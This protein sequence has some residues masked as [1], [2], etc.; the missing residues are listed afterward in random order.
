M[1]ENALN[2]FARQLDSSS[3][4]GSVQI[5]QARAS[6]E[7]QAQVWSAKQY[8][9][10]Q[11]AAF[12]RAME[13]CRRPSLASVATYAFP[14]GK[15]TVRGA[16]IRLAE[17]L[18]TAWGNVS[19][20]TME[21]SRKPG[22]SEMQAFAWDLESNTRSIQNFTVQHR[23][24]TKGGGYMLTDERDIYELTANAG[25]RR[26]RSRILAILPADLVEAA[27]DMCRQTMAGDTTLPL[28]DRIRRMIAAFDRLGVPIA[29][30]EKRL[31]RPAGEILADDLADLAG[32]HQSLKDGMSSVGDWFGTETPRAGGS[33]LA[34]AIKAQATRP[35][36]PPESP[37]ELPPPTPAAEAPQSTMEDSPPAPPE[38]ETPPPAE[39]PAAEAPKPIMGPPVSQEEFEQRK[40]ELE[41]AAARNGLTM[42]EA[43]ATCQAH[44]H[45]AKIRHLYQTDFERL[46]DEWIPAA[47][48]DKIAK[49]APHA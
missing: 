14:R 18:A 45:H 46:R 36:A 22:V 40:Q 49:E 37:A 32:I 2:P 44:V 11:A 10:D 16:S 27:L 24:D 6:T 26:M 33:A 15:E 31:G 43:G 7:V 35:V 48:Q 47:G 28:V 5:E 12:A 29:L 39:T 19:Y 23:R 30:I 41:E 4:A 9:R 13:A 20:G 3:H 17:E 8:P 1:I 25:A 34:D 21:L 42:K 38:V